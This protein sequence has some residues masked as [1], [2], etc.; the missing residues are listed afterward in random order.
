MAPLLPTGQPPSEAPM[1]YGFNG[2]NENEAYNLHERHDLQH[3][4]GIRWYT[5][6]STGGHTITNSSRYTG[7]YTQTIVRFN[8]TDA[9]RLPCRAVERDV[10]L[11][12]RRL[13]RNLFL[14]AGPVDVVALDDVAF[15]IIQEHLLVGP[16]YQHA[17]TDAEA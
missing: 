16:T 9:A 3:S 10:S 7:S 2:E 17:L 15:E 4:T 11:T 5:N 8:D 6:E 12:R 1:T 13:Q 14:L